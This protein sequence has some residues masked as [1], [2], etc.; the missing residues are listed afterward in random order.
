MG[1]EERSD[2]ALRIIRRLDEVGAMPYECVR[3]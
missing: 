3:K 1:R 2:L